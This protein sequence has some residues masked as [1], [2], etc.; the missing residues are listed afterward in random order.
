M[1]QR[2]EGE[3]KS[4]NR[5]NCRHHSVCVPGCCAANV[6]STSKATPYRFAVVT[7]LRPGKLMGLRIGDIKG[8]KLR[9][10]PG[11]QRYGET[12]SRKIRTPGE[13]L[14]EFACLPDYRAIAGATSRQRNVYSPGKPFVS[15]YKPKRKEPVSSM[16]VL[17]TL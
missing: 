1:H 4:Y 3:K 17:C 5:M 15:S 11:N 14:V 16:E 2:T 13:P 7:R 9:I 8:D 10:Q 12:T 6:Q